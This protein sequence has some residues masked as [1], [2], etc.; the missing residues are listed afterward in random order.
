MTEWIACSERLPEDNNHVLVSCVGGHVAVSFFS[1]DREFLKRYGNGYS[2][3]R[4][5]KNSGYFEISH[6][7]GYQITHWQPRP[8]PAPPITPFTAPLSGGAESNH[9]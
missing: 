1:L 6:Q 8:A 5:G 7:H 9:V 2:R 4:L 3:S